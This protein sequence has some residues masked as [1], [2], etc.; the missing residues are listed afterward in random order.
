MV[1][2]IRRATEQ[3]ARDNETKNT[4]TKTTREQ[5][6]YQ[7]SPAQATGEIGK[8]KRERPVHQSPAEMELRKERDK[9]AA[10]VNE[11]E[12]AQNEGRFSPEM[13]RRAAQGEIMD[14]EDQAFFEAQPDR[15]EEQSMSESVSLGLAKTLFGDYQEASMEADPSTSP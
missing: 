14:D 3:A 1:A 10:I 7:S 5:P 8:G 6:S 15:D 13:K 12:R 9:Q 4:P 11:N 2:T